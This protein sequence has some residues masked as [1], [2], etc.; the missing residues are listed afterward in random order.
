[1]QLPFFKRISTQVALATA[2]AS[3]LCFMLVGTI[4]FLQFEKAEITMAEQ[5]AYAQ[6]KGAKDILEYAY[7]NLE[8]G[9]IERMNTFK[10]ILASENGAFHPESKDALGLPVYKIG[11]LTVNGNEEFLSKWKNAIGADPALLILGPKGELIRAATLLKGPDGKSSVGTSI[12]ESAPESRNIAQ[13]KPWNGVVV[14]NGNYY[15]ST[16]E[17]IFQNGKPVGAW[18]VRQDVNKRIELV[19]NFAKDLKFGDT[20]YLYALTDTAS[21]QDSSFIIHPKFEGKKV[22]ETGNAQSVVERIFAGKGKV[23]HYDWI[24]E[25]GKA[26]PKMAASSL[27]DSWKWIIAGGTWTDEYTRESSH[28]RYVLFALCCAGALLSSVSAFFSSRQ[29]LAQALPLAHAV[30]ALGAGELNKSMPSAPC[31]LGIV[32]EGAEKARLGMTALTEKLLRT[33][34]EIAQ[35]SAEM[36]KVADQSLYTSEILENQAAGMS[37][38]SEQL[39]G[40]AAA[41]SQTA[42]EA[43]AAASQTLEACKN[44]LGQIL[45]MSQASE[46][47]HSAAAQTASN[48]DELAASVRQINDMAEAIGGLAEQTNLLALNAA[49]EAA[50]AG[51]SGRGFA[52]VADEVRKLAERSGEFTVQITQTVS[53]AVERARLAS[54]DAKRLSQDMDSLRQGSNDACGAVRL[55]QSQG[56]HSLMSSEQMAQSS[57]EQAGAAQSLSSSVDQIA[58][59]ADENAKRSR[60][61][62]SQAEDLMRLAD[63]LLHAADRFKI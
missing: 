24:G 53:Q 33:N 62:K 1:M 38:A 52:V 26:R 56:E 40:S 4:S 54:L 35:H 11:S 3:S 58:A 37:S 20:G 51:E 47:A 15:V 16:F 25:D 14:R 22:A 50:R 46:R 44:A 39:A 9:G 13:G 34:K 42:S 30:E 31:E 59:E 41:S 55:I 28:F 2:I 10:S 36:K 49:I 7:K 29:K 12:S 60:I 18:S 17:P 27:S 5:T 57:A 32:A 21:P 43:R 8:L 61:M 23:I 63:E 19:K 6:V 45:A 48:M